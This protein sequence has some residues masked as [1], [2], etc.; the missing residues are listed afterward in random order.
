MNQ[1]LLSDET[2]QGISSLANQ[3]NLSL[4]GLLEQI[5]NGNLAV[6]DAEELEDL[7]DVRDAMMAEADPENKER[8]SWENVKQNLGL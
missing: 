2:L 1:I 7:L 4:D 3:L 5:V 6:I 8:V